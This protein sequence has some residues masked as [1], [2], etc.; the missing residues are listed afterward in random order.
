VIVSFDRQNAKTTLVAYLLL[1][2]C[3]PISE[4]RA[5]RLERALALQGNEQ[6]IEG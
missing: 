1:H 4:K 6:R 5:A 3:G 2:L